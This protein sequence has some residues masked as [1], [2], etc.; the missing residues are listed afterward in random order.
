[1]PAFASASV[2]PNA[3]TAI[4][5][6]TA[7]EAPIQRRQPCASAQPTTSTLADT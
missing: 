4:A 1:M 3:A 2:A 7:T 6:L 5:I